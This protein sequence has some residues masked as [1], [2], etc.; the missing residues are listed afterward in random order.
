MRAALQRPPLQPRVV[1]L[2]DVDGDQQL[3]LAHH[4]VATQQRGAAAAE[5]ELARLRGPPARDAIGEG[6]EGGEAQRGLQRVHVARARG[7]WVA[8]WERAGELGARLIH[9][10]RGVQV[11]AERAGA[12][13]IEARSARLLQQVGQLGQ[14]G[15]AGR[16][17]PLAPLARAQIP[18]AQDGRDRAALLGGAARLRLL[19]QPREPRMECQPCGSFSARGDPPTGEEAQARE[20]LLGGLQRVL[21]GHIEPGQ[22]ARL[23]LLRAQREHQLGEIEPLHLGR[24][25]RGPGVEVVLGVE[26]QAE[27]GRG[28][29]GASR[30]LRRRGLRDLLHPQRRQA[31]P[32][33]VS[34]DPRQPRI[35]HRGNAVDGDA[36]LGDVGGED[37]LA[38]GAARDGA[39]LLLGRQL[40]VQREKDQ[41]AVRGQLAALLLR[42]ADLAGAG[43][44][45]EQIARG[46]GHGELAHRGRDLLFNPSLVWPLEVFERHRKAAALAAHH[47]GAQVLGER[48][49]V[50]RGRHGDELQVAPR[51]RADEPQRL[52]E[53]EIGLQVPLVELVEQHR[54]H[55]AQVGSSSS[56]REKSPSVR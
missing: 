17:G 35:D 41:I 38:L 50:Q 34:G 3:G 36:G 40:S 43:E 42:A 12:A 11:E 10:A 46:A 4:R 28:A 56:R 37:H 55:A 52:R 15:R 16:P 31:G 1:A 21:V 9:S 25:V 49:R 27:P 45:D 18:L 19:H 39:V 54:A 7:R 53:R 47:L 14:V 48:G 5:Q 30:S 32:G 8:A 23:Q 24:V 20:Q 2:L 51:A 26:A 33:R 29:A 22:G 6:G 44:E 13:G